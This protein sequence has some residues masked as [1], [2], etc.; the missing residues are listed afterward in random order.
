MTECDQRQ[1]T[2]MLNQIAAYDAGRIDL[3]GLISSLESLLNALQSVPESW[4]DQLRRQWGVLEEVY[5]VAVVREQPVESVNNRHLVDQAIT[6]IREII[7]SIL[8]D[9]GTP[10]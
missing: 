8:A 3:A 2:N 4:V 10:A 5:S 7:N 1:L 9:T 6:K